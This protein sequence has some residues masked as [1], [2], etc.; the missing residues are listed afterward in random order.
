MVQDL[1]HFRL[2]VDKIY[3]EFFPDSMGA[4]FF[5]AAQEGMHLPLPAQI[6]AS[7][8]GACPAGLRSFPSGTAFEPRP[9]GGSET[10]LLEQS[11][12]R[13]SQWFLG[14]WPERRS[15]CSCGRERRG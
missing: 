11:Q 1:P 9:D 6:P 2:T 12:N 7:D 4:A 5:K 3:A 15:V 14:I 10:T 8:K 13:S